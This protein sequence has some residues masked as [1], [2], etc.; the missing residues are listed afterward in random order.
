MR[1][2]L[3]KVY[4]ELGYTEEILYEIHSYLE[5]L[6]KNTMV[7]ENRR[8]RFGNFAKFLE[9]LVL[10]KEQKSHFKIEYVKHQLIQ[11][12]NVSFKEW[13]LDHYCSLENS[14]SKGNKT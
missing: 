3:L 8:I 12:E 10:V 1:N 13:L 9:K 6:R 2:L 14:L 7:S 5:F 4:Y 11:A